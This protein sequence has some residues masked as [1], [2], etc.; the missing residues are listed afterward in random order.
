MSQL[1]TLFFYE[2]PASRAINKNSSVCHRTEHKGRWVGRIAGMKECT[3]H[4][5][6]PISWVV[7][8]SPGTEVSSRVYGGGKLDIARR[9]A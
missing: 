9:A 5:Y 1:H 7:T 4:A 3:A 6:G 2:T 8:A